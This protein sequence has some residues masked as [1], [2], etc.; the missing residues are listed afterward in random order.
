MKYYSIGNYQERTYRNLVQKENRPAFRVVVKE[1]DLFVHAPKHLENL[2]RELILQYRGYIESYI[3]RYPEFAETLSPWYC[4]DPAPMIVQDMINAGIKAG[5]GPMS[6]VAGAVAEYVGRGLLLH[7]DEIIVENGGD[8]FLKIN[9]PAVVGIFA[10]KSPLSLRVGLRL[11]PDDT[12]LAV[13]TSSGTVGHS[14][15]FGKADAVCVASRS[16]ALADA[17]ATAIGNQVKSKADIQNALDFGKQIQGLSGI[18][19][20]ADDKIG[21]WGDLEMIPLKKR[22]KA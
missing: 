7:T 4:N 21:M 19:I 18:V 6:A 11:P 12:G 1:S 20:I 13:C 14:L 10:G 2:A 9:E 5:V 3:A 17:G 16:C 22:K 15:S 8:I